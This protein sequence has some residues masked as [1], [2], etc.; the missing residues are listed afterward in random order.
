MHKDAPYQGKKMFPLALTFFKPSS[1]AKCT[2]EQQANLSS[3]DN[4]REE[5]TLRNKSWELTLKHLKMVTQKFLKDRHKKFLSF[6]KSET[7]QRSRR[8]KIFQLAR[9]IACPNEASKCI[10][11][12]CNLSSTRLMCHSLPPGGCH[13]LEVDCRPSLCVDDRTPLPPHGRTA[14]AQIN[15]IA[16]R[17]AV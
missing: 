17:L 5:S 13:P 6:V 11:N 12:A 15:I 1:W 10:G 7:P 2:G 14:G 8:F 4:Q 9:F 3:S 16:V